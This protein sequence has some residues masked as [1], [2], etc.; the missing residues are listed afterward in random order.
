MATLRTNYKDDILAAAMDGKRQYQMINNPNG[1]VSFVDVTDYTQNG[2]TFSSGD[3]NAID[4][5]VNANT[6]HFDTLFLRAP[7]DI[8]SDL[9]NLTT[10]ISEQNL[11]KYGYKVGDYFIGSSGYTYWLADVDT[12]YTGFEYSASYTLASHHVGIIVD[13]HTD[14]QWNTTNNSGQYYNSTLHTFL[15]ST[16]LNKVKTDITQMI[17]TWSDHLLPIKYEDNHG[18]VTS[19]IIAP[20]ITHFFNTLA[21]NISYTDTARFQD[22]SYACRQLELFRKYH[23]GMV[24]GYNTAWTCVRGST[25]ALSVTRNGWGYNP[26][27]NEDKT[28]SHLALGLILLK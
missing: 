7:R 1:T 8:S 6:T 27:T 9:S 11:E 24:L 10:A 5:Q 13:T 18:D 17:G 2:D 23:Y 12:C 4:A 25:G 21:R 20:S 26:L 16:A 28:N 3:V 15:T 22:D 19:L 14:S